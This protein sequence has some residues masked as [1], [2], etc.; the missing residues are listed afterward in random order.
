VKAAKANGYLLLDHNGLQLLVD[1]VAGAHECTE[2]RMAAA[3]AGAAGAAA[4]GA[5]HLIT[6]ISHAE[7]GHQ[8][9]QHWLWSWVGLL[10]TLLTPSAIN[11][12]TDAMYQH[13]V[14]C[15]AQGGKFGCFSRICH[16]AVSWL[17]Y[18]CA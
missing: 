9:L 6:S 10:R 4:A 11:K 18:K 14:S 2:R 16:C 5:G 8:L 13:C 17:T 1:F 15:D 7:V 3:A 12:A